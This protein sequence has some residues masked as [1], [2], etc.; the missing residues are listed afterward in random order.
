MSEQYTITTQQITETG[1]PDTTLLRLG[2]EFDLEAHQALRDALLPPIAAGQDVL[3][4]F[5]AVTFLD[6]ESL[7]A[8]IEGFNAADAAGRRLRITGARGAVRRVLEVTGVW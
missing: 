5:G 6:S 1:R 7:G 2:G 4:D 8:L 3:V